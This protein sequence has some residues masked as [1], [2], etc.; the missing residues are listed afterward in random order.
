[1]NLVTSGYVSI[2]T[3]PRMLWLWDI[4]ELTYYVIP[5]LSTAS[6]MSSFVMDCKSQVSV[7]LVLIFLPED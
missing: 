1:M 4:E 3:L 7:Q 5:S 6:F 2:E